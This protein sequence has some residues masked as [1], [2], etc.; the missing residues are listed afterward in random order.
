M[1]RLL[2]SVLVAA[3]VA[4]CGAGLAAHVRLVHPS[5]PAVALRWNNPAGV[6]IVV[7]SIGSDD[8]PDGSHETALRM[9][10]QDW[11]DVTGTTATLVEDTSDAGQART[12]AVLRP[13]ESASLVSD[14]AAPL[15]RFERAII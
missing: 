7:S 9:A 5:N 10:I 14:I 8:I 3:V 4:L 1:G 6:S 15:A 2:G 12:S 11:N 13:W